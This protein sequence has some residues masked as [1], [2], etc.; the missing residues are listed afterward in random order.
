M[1]FV[2]TFGVF[3]HHCQ[4]IVGT[5]FTDGYRTVFIQQCTNAL[6]KRQIFG[7]GFIVNVRLHAVRI[8]VLNGFGIT[9]RCRRIA[10][11]CAVVEMKIAGIETETIN[12]T[13]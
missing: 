11:Q 6:Q 10:A 5:D 7:L 4:R 9:V 1:Q 3:R 13:R 8:S 2:I 12:A